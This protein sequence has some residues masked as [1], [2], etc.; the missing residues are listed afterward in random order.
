MIKNGGFALPMVVMGGLVITVV[1]ATI[2]L[3]GMKDNVDVISRQSQDSAEAVAEAGISR[4]LNEIASNREIINNRG[5][6]K[7]S[8]VEEEKSPFECIIR[9]QL[10]ENDEDGNG[11]YKIESGFIFPV[12]ER[13]G[14]VT[15]IDFDVD[16]DEREGALA[17]LGEVGEEGFPTYAAAQIRINFLLEEDG[18]SKLIPDFGVGLW[19]RRF[20]TSAPVHAN[21]LDSSICNDGLEQRPFDGSLGNLPALPLG[22]LPSGNRVPPLSN[23]ESRVVTAGIGFPPLPTFP[24]REIFSNQNILDGCEELGDLP[25]EGDVLDNGSYRYY[26]ENGCTIPRNTTI[27]NNSDGSN[28]FFYVDGSFVVN[29]N[30]RLFSS[31]NKI[32]WHLLNSDLV[33]RGNAQVG[34]ASPDGGTA[35]NW[36]FFLHNGTTVDLRGNAD[37]YAFIYAPYATADLRGNPKIGGGLWVNSIET[38]GNPPKVFQAIDQENIEEIFDMAYGAP[39]QKELSGNEEF[40]LGPIVSF[41]REEVKK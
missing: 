11:E 29:N 1:G 24:T 13:D 30:L 39:F 16:T 38:S 17:V 5:K 10:D 21:V 26:V 31:N 4:V 41:R 8:E 36:S 7:S 25:R 2:V 40:R 23:E 33:L 6:N 27:G 3:R 9:E 37:H 32:Q 34:N 35:S 15:I 28:F 14:R 12:G 19:A 18:G 20:D 22:S